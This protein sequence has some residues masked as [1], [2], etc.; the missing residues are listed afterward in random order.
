MPSMHAHLLTA[1]LAA[2]TSPATTNTLL[3]TTNMQVRG[4]IGLLYWARDQPRT[5][6]E[7]TR[8]NVHPR[9]NRPQPFVVRPAVPCRGSRRPLQPSEHRMDAVVHTTKTGRA[10]GRASVCQYG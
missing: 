7:E 10:S 3:A 8:G 9:S 1:K 6:T 5:R 2:T 4:N